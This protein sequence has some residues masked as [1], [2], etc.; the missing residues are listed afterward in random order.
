MYPHANPRLRH[1]EL[2]AAISPNAEERYQNFFWEGFIEAL[3]VFVSEIALAFTW[4]ERQVKVEIVRPIPNDRGEM[5]AR[6]TADS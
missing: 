2:S 4:H 5:L 3:E 6:H 1:I